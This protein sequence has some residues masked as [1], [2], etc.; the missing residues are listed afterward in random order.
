MALERRAT[1]LA[2][3][4]GLAPR[5]L[6]LHRDGWGKST[7]ANG[8]TGS[9]KKRFAPAQGDAERQRSSQTDGG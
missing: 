2:I 1:L 4:S 3:T 9:L 8:A 6:R 5:Q 7:C